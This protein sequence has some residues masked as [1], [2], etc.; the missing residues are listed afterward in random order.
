MYDIASINHK[1]T[2]KT[3][4][5]LIQ[6]IYLYKES[7]RNKGDLVSGIK[8]NITKLDLNIPDGIKTFFNPLTISK[9]VYSLI[10][11]TMLVFQ[12]KR[13]INMLRMNFYIRKLFGQFGEENC[14][15]LKQ[16]SFL[17]ELTNG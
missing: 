3:T 17:L 2:V 12:L 11:K 5:V 6:I 14:L 4:L 8:T 10:Y 9:S 16:I 7:P 1:Y 13:L 15:S